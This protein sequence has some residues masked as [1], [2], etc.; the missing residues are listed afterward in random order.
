MSLSTPR[1]G[2]EAIPTRERGN[3]WHAGARERVI[4]SPVVKPR[5]GEVNPDLFLSR[6]RSELLSLAARGDHQVL[7]VLGDGAAGDLDTLS[8][9]LIDDFFV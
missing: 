2:K 7:A 4:G 9:H 5:A 3:E 6:L 1:S 8:G